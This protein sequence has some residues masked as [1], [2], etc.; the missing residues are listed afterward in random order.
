MT[1]MNIDQ[2]MLTVL[3]RALGLQGRALKFTAQTRLLGGLPELDSLA[4]TSL[5]AEIEA[6]FGL[7]VADDEI[8][9]SVF[10]SVG[11][12]TDFV[13]KRLSASA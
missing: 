6:R 10:A 2:E 11:T 4:L 3:D 5:I 12:L 9:G 1:I 13:H 8:D 7:I